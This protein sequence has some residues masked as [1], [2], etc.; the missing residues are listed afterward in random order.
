MIGKKFI[1]LLVV[2]GLTASIGVSAGAYTKTTN[3]KTKVNYTQNLKFNRPA[4]ENGKINIKSK[5]DALV[6]AGTI[7]Q[8]VEDK[9]VTYFNQKDT[10][11]KAEMDKVK[12]MTEA[13]RKTYFDSKVKAAGE[14]TDLFADIVKSGTITQVEADAIKAALPQSQRGP[15]MM[16]G[17]HENGQKFD[18][19]KS[20][21]LQKDMKT[22]LDAIVKSGTITQA[23]E[24]QVIAYYNK[25]G[26]DR[27]AEMDKIKAMTEADR[28]VYFE[29]KVKGEGEKSGPL[30]SLVK[31]GT[32]TQVQ[33]D[34]INKVFPEHQM[35]HGMG[36]RR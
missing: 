30:A 7:T 22:K 4:P 9:V 29:S 27:K 14:R 31:A 15:G 10:D 28:K 36:G 18:G 6:K 17:R 34:A 25:M 1:A 16:G 24:D 33:A 3:V 2:G 5:L 12:A 8:V 26:S 19:V 13:D 11:R 20:V 21:D 35:G 23:T 32:L